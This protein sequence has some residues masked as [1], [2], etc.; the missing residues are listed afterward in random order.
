MEYSA[1]ASWLAQ[2]LGNSAHSP[3]GPEDL[4]EILSVAEVESAEA[5]SVIFGRNDESTKVF[6]LETGRVALTR[7]SSERTPMLQILNPGDI[8]G[9]LAVLLGRLS[10]VDAVVLEDAQFLTIDGDELLWLVSTRPRIA[11]RWM[12]SIAARLAAAQDR[13]EE[14]LAGPLDY[15]LASLLR[16]AGDKDGIIRVSQEMLAQLLGAR[17]PSIARSL[18]NLERQGLIEKQ[19]RWIKIVDDTRLEA[20]LR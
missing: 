10:P 2:C 5:G 7:P 4:A 13:L 15:Q 20:L 14:L 1:R 16:H 3:L 6:I 9:D 18:A 19:Y 12:V 8:F 17:R 11:I